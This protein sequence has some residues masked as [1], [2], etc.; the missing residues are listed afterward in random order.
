MNENSR[1]GCRVALVTGAASGIGLATAR[2]LLNS[3]M[4]VVLTDVVDARLE[5]LID[6][7]AERASFIRHDVTDEAGWGR[8]AERVREMGGVLDVLVNAAGIVGLDAPQDPESV[9]SST[10][11]RVFAVNLDGAR[12]GCKAMLPLLRM[13]AAGAIVNVSSCAAN[14]GVAGAVAYGASKAAL[15]SLSRS[16]ALH[17]AAR[18]YPV[19]C[20]TVLPGAILTPLW[21][22][23]FGD[24]PDRKGREK[25]VA[26]RVPLKRFGRPEEVA[27]AICFL[28]SEAASFITGTELVID[29]GE[30][31][32]G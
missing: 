1:T 27:E 25:A 4:R 9:E 17:C 26:D 15:V 19:R 13:S 32:A 6:A 16:I 29:G 18:G 14:I 20:N 31:V 21:D 30:S 2:R 23:F 12:L 7:P 3:G 11:H 28:A 5:Q 8:L 10:W 22:P 24:G